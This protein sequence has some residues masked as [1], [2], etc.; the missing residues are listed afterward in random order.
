MAA[1]TTG[2]YFDRFRVLMAGVDI[3]GKPGNVVSLMVS[4]DGGLSWVDGFSENH[5]PSG[6][7]LANKHT[8]FRFTE[9]LQYNVI[10]V[11][12]DQLDYDNSP[13]DIQLMAPTSQYASDVYGAGGNIW[14]MKKVAWSNEQTAA[15]YAANTK[16]DL[17][18]FVTGG[19]YWLSGS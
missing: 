19:S 4:I 8:M 10:P 7:L 6:V 2:F 13:I 14:V 16:R 3:S 18:F 1:P 15:N 17:E 9:N 12:F 5:L 11:Q